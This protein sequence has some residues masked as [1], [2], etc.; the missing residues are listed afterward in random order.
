MKKIMDTV[1]AKGS[2]LNV[3]ALNV[4]TTIIPIEYFQKYNVILAIKMNGKYM[5]V[6]DKGPLFIIYPYESK[7]ELDNQFYY[8]RSAWQINKMNIE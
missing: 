2:I 6:R 8:S 5:R 4:Y 7:Q 3:T 1:R